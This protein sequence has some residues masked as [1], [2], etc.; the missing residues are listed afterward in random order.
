[1]KY[2]IL[3]NTEKVNSNPYNNPK[4][5]ELN[6]IKECFLLPNDNNLVLIS[7]ITDSQEQNYKIELTLGYKSIM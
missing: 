6:S 5:I 4:L 1:M 3:K 2:F 7:K